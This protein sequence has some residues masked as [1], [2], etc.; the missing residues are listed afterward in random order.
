MRRFSEDSGRLRP[1]P[2]H[3]VVGRRMGK[4][5]VLIQLRTNRVYTLNRTGARLWELL[6]AG[7]D[8]ATIQDRLAQEFEVGETA[9]ANEID[10]LLGKLA[11]EKLLDSDDESSGAVE[12]RPSASRRS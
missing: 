10:R 3:D 11:D 6:E 8:R 4:E 1:R 12:E 7:C 5:F 2:N 9:L